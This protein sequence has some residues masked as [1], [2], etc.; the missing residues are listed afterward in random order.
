M[1]CGWHHVME[2]CAVE[3]RPLTSSQPYPEHRH[4]LSRGFHMKKRQGLWLRK[5]GLILLA[6][7]VGNAVTGG[8]SFL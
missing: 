6:A 4:N 2:C 7:R 8:Q 1:R 3:I 5:G